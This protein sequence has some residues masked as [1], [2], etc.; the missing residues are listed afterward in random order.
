MRPCWQGVRFGPHAVVGLETD[1]QGAGISNK[2]TVQTNASF[3]DTV[4]GERNL[5]WFGTV[6]GRLGYAFD[7]TLLY[8]TGGFAYDVAGDAFR[9]AGRVWIEVRFCIVGR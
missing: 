9:V 1:F 5:D 8:A 7:A 3:D 4:A 2:N 6:R